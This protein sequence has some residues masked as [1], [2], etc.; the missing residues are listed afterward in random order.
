MLAPRGY[1][2]LVA[3][4]VVVLAAC[5]S[6]DGVAGGGGSGG[7]G[8]GGSGGQGAT[9]NIGGSSGSSG[10]GGGQ[11]GGF[12]IGSDGVP[13]GFTKADLGAWKLGP[14]FDG[15]PPK[16]NECG[17]VLL[18]VVR[19]FKD[20]SAGG[21]PDFETFTGNGLQ[22]IVETDLGSDQ[23]PVYAHAGATQYTTTPDNFKQWYIN[24]DGVNEAFIIY[25]FLVPNQGIYTFESNDF[26]PLDGAG[27]GNEGNSHNFHFTTELHTKFEYKGGETFSFQGDDDLWVFINGKLAIDLGGLHPV[28]SDTI[29]LDS[30]AGQL[31]IS[32]GNVYTLDLF[33]AERHTNES[34]FR[35]DT[36][37]EFIDCGTTVPEPT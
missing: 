12:P 13:V 14:K 27:F 24:V 32:V 8:G 11:G 35:I 34:N 26:F 19:D 28:Q 31:G 7:Q 17:S 3:V 15:T 5:G 36:N 29:N 18:G 37:L 21:H 33:H 16:L 23:K 9:I 4:A 20:G 25:F 1:V 30:A 2:C 10:S 22:G 6:D